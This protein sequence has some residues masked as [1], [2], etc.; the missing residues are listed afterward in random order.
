MSVEKYDRLIDRLDRLED[1]AIGQQ[2]QAALLTSRMVG[3]EIFT[4]ELQR[5]A[6]R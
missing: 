3:S 2:A 5:L 6:A 4:A 1:L